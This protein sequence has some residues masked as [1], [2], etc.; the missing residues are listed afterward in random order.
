MGTNGLRHYAA[1]NTHKYCHIFGQQLVF[2]GLNTWMYRF[3]QSCIQNPVKTSKMET[4]T[5]I[6]DDEKCRNCLHIVAVFI[7]EIIL[8]RGRFRASLRKIPKFHRIYWC[9]NFVKRHSFPQI[10]WRFYRTSAETVPF[11][12]ISKPRN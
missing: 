11:Q 7:S 6:V 5:K 3:W 10:S 2:S 1:W 12:K 8:T 9:G 4:F